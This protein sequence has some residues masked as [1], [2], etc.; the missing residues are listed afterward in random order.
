MVTSGDGNAA[1][2][3]TAA[4]VIARI[5][6]SCV[7]SLPVTGA[8][9]SIMTAEGHGGV[10]FATDDTARSLED[11]Q[12]TLG[13]GPGVDAFVTG[14]AQL[15]PDV[16]GEGGP[17]G[18]G[19]AFRV[20]AG[21]FGV[22]ALLALPLRLGAASLGVL[23]L[24]RTEAGSLDGPDMAQAVRWANTA[25]PALLDLMVNL[26]AEGGFVEQDGSPVGPETE[27]FRTEIYQAAGMVMVQLG[28]SIEVAMVRL[29]ARAFASGRATGD[30]ARDVVRR[31]I[32]FEADT[33]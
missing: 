33:E 11:L 5:C 13:A 6:E 21:G 7:R 1:G 25:A 4:L 9:V 10:V 29:R 23:T 3:G 20:A 8:A 22:R 17:A 28:V 12:F 18:G 31:K 16:G 24:Y 19:P 26:A 14:A 27:I 32:F 2:A 15:M 30:I